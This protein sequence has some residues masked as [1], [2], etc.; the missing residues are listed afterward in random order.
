MIS[1]AHLRIVV[2][3]AFAPL[4]AGCTVAKTRPVAAAAPSPFMPVGDAVSPPTGFIGFCLRND[5]ECSGGTDAPSTPQLTPPLWRDLN[6]VND[7]VNRL[8]Q[9]EDEANYGTREYWAYPNARGGDC[10]DLALEKRRL[11]IA[12]GLPA[13]ALLLATAWESDGTLHAVL[14][15][16]TDRGDYVL[17]NKNW[18]IVRWSEA[19][20]AWKARQ[21]RGRPYLWVDAGA[22]AARN[23]PDLPPLGA[24]A[25]FLRMARERTPA[26]ATS[27]F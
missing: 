23:A 4:L 18:A 8:P 3:L 7:Y 22:G 10:E 15:V 25:P 13:D 19:P 2:L 6:A 26:A 27:S 21:S 9:I 1:A 5:A 14:V 12:R 17:D 20:Y 11:L 16:L 24:P